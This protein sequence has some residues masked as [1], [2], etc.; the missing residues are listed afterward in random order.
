MKG[1]ALIRRLTRLIPEPP[2]K[3]IVVTWF[4]ERFTIRNH[5]ATTSAILDDQE[6]PPPPRSDTGAQ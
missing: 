2:P 6:L 4:N 3:E 1:D 5:Q